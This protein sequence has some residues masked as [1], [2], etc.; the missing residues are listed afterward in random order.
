MKEVAIVTDTYTGE[1][2]AYVVG[3]VPKDILFLVNYGSRFTMSIM[4]ATMSLG[5]VIAQILN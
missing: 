3:R 2:R 1:A 5:F 4:P